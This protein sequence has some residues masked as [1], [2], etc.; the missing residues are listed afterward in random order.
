VTADDSM[1]PRAKR[2]PGRPRDQRATSA[3]TEAALRQ[4]RDLGYA[5][6][7]LESVASEAGVSRATIYRRYRDK[8]DLITAAIAA[9]STR[10]LD[11]DPS[12]DPRADVVS[13]LL[14]FDERYSEHCLE[15][16]GSLIGARDDPWA[17]ALHRERVVW[18]RMTYLRTLLVRAQELGQLREDA[19]LDL[20]LQ[21]LTGSVFARRVAGMDASPGWA[22][23]A[24]DAIWSGMGE[25]SPGSVVQSSSVVAVNAG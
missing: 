10:H 18:P 14:E 3:I 23:R 15:V 8:A 20:A 11:S 16:L 25:E 21:M 22:Q 4:L 7:S 1:K 13:Y 12:E 9:N 24:V 2:R 6:V 5:K 17:M 19:D